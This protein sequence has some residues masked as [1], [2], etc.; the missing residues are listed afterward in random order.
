MSELTERDMLQRLVPELEAE[1]Y[2]V[3]IEPRKPL[4]PA[5]LENFRPDAVAIREGK[6][7]VIEVMRQSPQSSVKLQKLQRL[8]QGQPDWE[9]RVVWVTPSSA[10]DILRLQP[11][12]SIKD[13]I[14]SI[15]KLSAA[16]DYQPAILMAW[17][18][19]EALAR[20][21]LVSQ[22]GR[23][24]SPGRIV[25]VL[26]SEGYITP[27][28]ADLLR[29]LAAKRNG[30]IHGELHISVSGDDLRKFISILQEM[31]EELDRKTESSV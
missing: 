15:E 26:A 9:L 25:Q 30:I 29:A 5:F 6:N 23:P 16:T 12:G 20:L 10:P 19:F 2:D 17:A 11:L 1:G 21:T 13:H 24:Q 31:L 28:E 3:F 7:L 22:F 18:T 4:V 27:S 14:A 8:M